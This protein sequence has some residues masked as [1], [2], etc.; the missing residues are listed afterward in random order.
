M[1]NIPQNPEEYRAWWAENTDVPYG[2]CHCSCGQQTSRATRSEP[3]TNRIKGEPMRFVAGHAGRFYKGGT[4]PLSALCG[5]E[6]RGY[7]SPCL[8]WRG[9]RDHNG[10]GVKRVDGRAL[11]AHRYFWSIEHGPIPDGFVIHHKCRVQ[12]CIRLEHLEPMKHG[13][14]SALHAAE[15]GFGGKLRWRSR[16]NATSP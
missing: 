7:E 10:Y 4:K 5:A 13:D 14:H 12:E 9:F 1:P 11:A 6:D 8:I 3:Y 16:P 15:T 2:F